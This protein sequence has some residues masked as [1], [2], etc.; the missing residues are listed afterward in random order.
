M[1]GFLLDRRL[2]ASPAP[3]DKLPQEEVRSYEP[4]EAQEEAEVEDGTVFVVLRWR[5]RMDEWVDGLSLV[6]LLCARRMR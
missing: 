3:S 5:V 4:A 2:R 6:L 1:G